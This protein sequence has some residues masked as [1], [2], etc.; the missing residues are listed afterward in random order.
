MEGLSQRLGGASRSRAESCDMGCP[1]CR[2][3][4]SLVTLA[5]GSWY[6]SALRLDVLHGG[7]EH[8]G[9]CRDPAVRSDDE[10]HAVE[11]GDKPG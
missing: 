4:R 11:F 7:A 10:V 9:V 1:P 6:C 8:I 5:T 3:C 2:Y